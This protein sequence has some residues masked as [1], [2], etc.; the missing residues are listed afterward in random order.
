[1]IAKNYFEDMSIVHAVCT[2]M[3]AFCMRVLE[4]V[5]AAPCASWKA[6]NHLTKSLKAFNYLEE[7][8]LA[9][10]MTYVAVFVRT[11]ATH[12]CKT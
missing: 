11:E 8:L 2:G 3:C 4:R 9:G 10:V 6:Y 1:M 5:H 12:S 7:S